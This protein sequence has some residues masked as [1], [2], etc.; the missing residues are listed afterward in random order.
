M[1]GSAAQQLFAL[2]HHDEIADGLRHLEFG[3]RKHDAASRI[4]VNQREDQRDIVHHRLADGEPLAAG[5][6]IDKGIGK[7]S[8]DHAPCPSPS[9]MRVPSGS[10]ASKRPRIPAAAP[11][12]IR[13]SPTPPRSAANAALSFACIPPVATPPAISSSL[14]EAVRRAR[15]CLAPSRTPSTSVRKIN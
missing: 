9:T 15:T 8:A 1:K 11:G 3:S 10:P 2:H 5:G 7:Q 14:S 4:I 12:A 6:R 13:T